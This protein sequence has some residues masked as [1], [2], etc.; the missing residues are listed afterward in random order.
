MYALHFGR[1]ARTRSLAQGPSLEDLTTLGDLFGRPSWQLDGACR[2]EDVELFI[3]SV[4]GNFNR[5][6]QMC[7]GCT[8]RTKCLDFGLADKDIIG[9]WGGRGK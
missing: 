4:G 5:A 3:P 1:G 9:M 6:R 8:V 2:G 7:D